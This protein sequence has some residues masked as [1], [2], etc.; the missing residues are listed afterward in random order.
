MDSEKFLGWLDSV[1][2]ALID[3]PRLDNFAVTAETWQTMTFT[4]LLH[5]NCTAFSCRPLCRLL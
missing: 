2:A 1:D 3:L 4:S 5:S